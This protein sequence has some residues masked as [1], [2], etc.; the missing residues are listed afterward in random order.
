MSLPQRTASVARRRRS[1]AEAAEARQRH[2]AGIRRTERI[3]AVILFAVVLL[4]LAGVGWRLYR[5]A[6]RAP[7]A[8]VARVID[9]D[10][11]ELAG[12]HV[13]LWG[14]D[15]PEH[16]QACA[17]PGG[18]WPAGAAATTALEN[19]AERSMVVCSV[20]D[21]DRDR[22]VAV[23]RAGDVDLGQA[24]VEAGLAYDYRR[25]SRGAYGAAEA[26]A[27]TARRGVWAAGVACEQPSEWRAARR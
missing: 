15:A 6:T 23:C 17:A 7:L 19:L 3:A 14:I 22:L 24:L 20:R 9:G 4:A 26:L 16:R 1:Q 8:G 10:T 18:E 5:E 21:H 27:R 2:F 25:Y 12:Q 11:I 13:R